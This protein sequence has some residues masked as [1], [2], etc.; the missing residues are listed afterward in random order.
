[1]TPLTAN[2]TLVVTDGSGTV[3]NGHVTQFYGQNAT[4]TSAY[5]GGQIM[6]FTMDTQN[7]IPTGVSLRVQDK[8]PEYRVDHNTMVTNMWNSGSTEFGYLIGGL[9]YYTLDVLQNIRRE[10]RHCQPGVL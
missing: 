4:G 8:M 10:R 9:K 6:S 5:A 2:T 7:E 1:M 3:I